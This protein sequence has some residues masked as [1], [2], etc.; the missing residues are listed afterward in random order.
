MQEPNK[1]NYLCSH[2]SSAPVYK[3]HVDERLPTNQKRLIWST[4]QSR[5]LLPELNNIS[6]CYLNQ[7][8]KMQ[9][10]HIQAL[11]KNTMRLTHVTEWNFVQR[12]NKA[13]F[14]AMK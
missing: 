6:F 13:L 2:A 14:Y 9:F 10:C 3:Q 12:C 5:L 7:G 4:Q 1:S 8:N 11:W